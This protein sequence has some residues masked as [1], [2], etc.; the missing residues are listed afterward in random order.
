[1]GELPPLLTPQGPGVP[2]A[3]RP[4]FPRVEDSGTSCSS[5][6]IFRLMI[7]LP[8]LAASAS[9]TS[10]PLFLSRLDTGS[11]TGLP[12]LV[13]RCFSRFPSPSLRLVISASFPTYMTQ[14]H[15][16]PPTH[17]YLF[18]SYLALPFVTSSLSDLFAAAFAS[19]DAPAFSPIS[20][21]I[22]VLPPRFRGSVFVARESR[23]S[24]LTPLPRSGKEH[25][26]M[27]GS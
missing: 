6:V 23:R 8:S 21:R 12:A 10:S 11:S 25:R 7:D 24:A 20:F 14:V 1:M 17:V 3:R 16:L 15:S 13:A 9:G 27:G 18:S 26:V 2:R 4:G 22:P 5:F 19:T